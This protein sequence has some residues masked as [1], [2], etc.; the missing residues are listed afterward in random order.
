MTAKEMEDI[1][2]IKR[3]NNGCVVNVEEARVNF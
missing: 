1:A 3:S 2:D